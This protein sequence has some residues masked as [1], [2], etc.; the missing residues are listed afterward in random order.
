MVKHQLQSNIILMKKSWPP[1]HRTNEARGQLTSN[2]ITV[3][4][5]TFFVAFLFAEKCQSFVTE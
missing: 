2:S 5:K 3:T 4:D 1:V